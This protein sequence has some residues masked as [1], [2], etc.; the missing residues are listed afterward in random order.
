MPL[1]APVVSPRTYHHGNLRAELLERAEQ[2]LA[3][4]GV[5]ALSLRALARD[6]GVSH[7][8]PARHFRDR[9][10][11]LDALAIDG[12]QRLNRAMQSAA[13]DDAALRDRFERV[14]AAYVEFATTHAAL[15]GLMYAHKHAEGAPEELVEAGHGSLAVAVDLVV[16]GQA[17]GQVREGDPLRLA[18]LAF[19]TVHGLAALAAGDLLEGAPLDEMV[20]LAADGLWRALRA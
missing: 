12:F 20:A 18:Q 3:T 2:T 16:E 10:A 8:A 5:D 1:A 9:Q 14:G 17:A 6:I 11:L 15:L 7:A 19:A 13:R 4:D